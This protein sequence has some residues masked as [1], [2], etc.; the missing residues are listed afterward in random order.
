MAR[1]IRDDVTGYVLAHVGGDPVWLAAGD[2]VPQGANVSE[3]LLQPS[4]RKSTDKRGG[5]RASSK[6]S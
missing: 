2:E 6:Q 1:T 5:R 4:V 3:V